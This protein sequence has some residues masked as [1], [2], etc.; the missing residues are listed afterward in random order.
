MAQ[1]NNIQDFIF[2]Y[3]MVLVF[4]IYDVKYICKFH[5]G[6]MTWTR[7]KIMESNR[8]NLKQTLQYIYSTSNYNESPAIAAPRGVPSFAGGYESYI[9]ASKCLRT[10]KVR[11]GPLSLH[12]TLAVTVNRH[13][14]LKSLIASRHLSLQLVIFFPLLPGALHHADSFP[15]AALGSLG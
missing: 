7:L 11:P 6:G 9:R 2:R 12:L 3:A 8:A 10:W 4:L 5:S 1:K 14:W 13:C 15:A